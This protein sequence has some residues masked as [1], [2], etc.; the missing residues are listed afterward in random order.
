MTTTSS[1]SSWPQ[2]YAWLNPPLGYISL[3]PA[4][5]NLAAAHASLWMVPEL[6]GWTMSRRFKG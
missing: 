3:R 6:W 2:C 4:V 1:P 5:T